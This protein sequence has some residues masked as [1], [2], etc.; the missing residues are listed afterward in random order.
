MEWLKGKKTYLIAAVIIL[1]AL[2]QILTGDV[3]IAQALVLVLEGLGL[4]AL[5]LGVAKSSI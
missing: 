2:G 1:T 3:T 4:G 5:R